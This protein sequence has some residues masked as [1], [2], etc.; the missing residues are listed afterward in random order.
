MLTVKTTYSN[1]QAILKEYNLEKQ[2][3][4]CQA[5]ASPPK[6]N[7]DDFDYVVE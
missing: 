3:P 6:D 2:A 1:F 7:F 5:A 4:T